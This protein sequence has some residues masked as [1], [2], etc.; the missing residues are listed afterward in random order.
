MHMWLTIIQSSVN[1]K[2]KNELPFFFLGFN[3]RRSSVT[4]RSFCAFDVTK[5]FSFMQSRGCEEKKSFPNDQKGLLCLVMQVRLI[6]MKGF[7]ESSMDK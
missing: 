1:I 3:S 6:T 7:K 2:G 4:S 5:T